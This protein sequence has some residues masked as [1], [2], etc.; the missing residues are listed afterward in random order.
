MS[1]EIDKI[2]NDTIDYLYHKYKPISPAD[3]QFIGLTIIH[4]SFA[5]VLLKANKHFFIEK[6]V[7]KDELLYK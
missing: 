7:S 1:S 5:D 6:E 4:L 2:A 3:I